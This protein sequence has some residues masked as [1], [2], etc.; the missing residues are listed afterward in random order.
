M[1]GKSNA[2]SIRSTPEFKFGKTV[3]YADL[4][5]G[6]EVGVYYQ[7]KRSNELTID[8]FAVMNREFITK[9]LPDHPALSNKKIMFFLIFFQITVAKE[10]HVV[11]GTVLRRFQKLAKDHLKLAELPMALIFVTYVDGLSKLQ[12]VTRKDGKGKRK[13]LRNQAEFPQF[14]A[15]VENNLNKMFVSCA[16][17]KALM[18]SEIIEADE[19]KDVVEAED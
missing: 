11:N 6:V 3:R 8:S 12:A 18:E 10:K 4:S 15:V 14:R 7:P 5:S 9:W 19:V 2:K 16:A 1:L 17:D 13:A